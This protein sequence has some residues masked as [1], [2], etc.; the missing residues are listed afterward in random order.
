MEGGVVVVG[1][2]ELLVGG[3]GGENLN[4]VLGV[5]VLDVFCWGWGVEGFVW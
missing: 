3:G 2:R 4:L 1:V 5:G